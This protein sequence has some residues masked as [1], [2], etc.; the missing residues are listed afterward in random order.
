MKTIAIAANPQKDTDLSFTR[1]VAAALEGRCN[2]R[3]EQEHGAAFCDDADAVIVLGGDG[4]ILSV[5]RRVAKKGLPILGINLGT[6]GFLAEIEPDDMEACLEQFLNDDYTLEERYML[7]A[8]VMRG[9]HVAAQACALNDFVVSSASVKRVVSMDIYVDDS[10]VGSYVADGVA[11]STPTGSTA[12]SLS[13]G[14]PIVD[15]SMAVTIITPVCPHTLSSRPLVIPSNRTVTVICRDE[16]AHAS[17]LTVD[18]QEGIPL[19]IGDR[20][21]VRGS[22]HTTRLIKVN[23]MNFY[24][25]LRKKIGG[26]S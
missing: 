8:Q 3:L 16:Y 26:R 1:R 18:G 4:T 13:A 23:H 7:D 25:I 20:I 19:E 15:S 14:G 10:L 24:E 21:V 17:M 5:A 2:V 22:E 9:D 12:Y 11:L 6:L